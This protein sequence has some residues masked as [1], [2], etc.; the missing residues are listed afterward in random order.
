MK[1]LFAVALV[2]A[3]AVLAGC[4]PQDKPMPSKLVK[5][6]SLLKAVVKNGKPEYEANQTH[7]SRGKQDG[8]CWFAAFKDG[9]KGQPIM[10]TETIQMPDKGVFTTEGADWKATSS[11]DGKVWTIKGMREATKN[12]TGNC[13]EISADDPLGDYTLAVDINGECQH[14]FAFTIEQ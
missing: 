6:V 9:Y 5:G 7:F 1:K 13:W 14:T 10:V 8:Y 2:L 4:M 3:C 12:G 11:A